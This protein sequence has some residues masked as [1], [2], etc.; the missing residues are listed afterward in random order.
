METN[1]GHVQVPLLRVMLH[2]LSSLDCILNTPS[3]SVMFDFGM[4]LA[5]SI[6]SIQ[7]L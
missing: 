7:R 1:A 4:D 3:T 6:F 2:D 5:L